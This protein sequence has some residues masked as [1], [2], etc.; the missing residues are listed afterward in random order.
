M[1]NARTD[2]TVA[3][4]PDNP[5][6]I[7][8]K[9]Y[10]REV[11]NDTREINV[12][13]RLFSQ[14]RRMKEAI[15]NFNKT[16]DSSLTC[17]PINGDSRE[18]SKHVDSCDLVITSPP[19]W[20]AQNYQKLHKLS[21]SLFGLTIDETDEIGRNGHQK[22][23][24]D[25]KTINYE[26]AQVLKGYYGLVIGEDKKNKEHLK[27]VE[28]MLDIGY[29]LEDTYIREIMNQAFFSKQIKREFIYVFK[30]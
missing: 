11:D 5:I 29:K 19:Y 7:D 23:Q 22:Y 8:R 20:S 10:Y 14:I 9:H 24:E 1:S 3:T 16:T 4:L 21:F 15:I 17:K 6:Y 27:V 13:S 2:N 18:L 25:M 12:Y 28:N 26:I 30:V